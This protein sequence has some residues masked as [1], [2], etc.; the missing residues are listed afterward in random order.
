[1]AVETEERI[2]PQRA[3]ERSAKI[4]FWYCMTC[5]GLTPAV[6]GRMGRPNHCLHCSAPGV[7][8]QVLIEVEGRRLT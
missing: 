2:A 1:M 3:A 4:W 5:Y 8:L 7:R 6:P